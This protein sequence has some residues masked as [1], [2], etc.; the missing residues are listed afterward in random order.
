MTDNITVEEKLRNEKIKQIGKVCDNI[1][2][3]FNNRFYKVRYSTTNFS[4]RRKIFVDFD[5]YSPGGIPVS[6]LQ[7]MKDICIDES[8]SIY[9]LF[10]TD[11]LLRVQTQFVW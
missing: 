4:N 10:F 2:D 8:M 7:I 5:F 1:V 3:Y 9:W 6:F 11:G